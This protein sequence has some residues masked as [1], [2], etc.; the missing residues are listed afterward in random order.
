MKKL[1]ALLMALTM[2]AALAACGTTKKEDETTNQTTTEETTT[3]AV[4]DTTAPAGQENETT[5]GENANVVDDIMNDV[6]GKIPADQKPAVIGGHYSAEYTEGPASYDLAY[7]E[8]LAGMLL[9]P[10]DQIGNVVDASTA[11]HMMNANSMT[12]GLVKLTEGADQQAF[13]D[14]VYD[15]IKNNQWMCGFPEKLIIAQVEGDYILIAYGLNDILNTFQSQL[16]ADWTVSDFYNEAI[17]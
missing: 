4:E 2:I 5:G 6:W 13:A 8:E 11:V 15:T 10:E 12:I 16:T 3:E 7:A 14:A 1:I 9:I 17:G